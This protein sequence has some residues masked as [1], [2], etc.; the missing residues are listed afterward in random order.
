MVLRSKLLKLKMNVFRVMA[1]HHLQEDVQ[2]CMQ[3]SP[4]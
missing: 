2:G 3:K 4:D 1:R